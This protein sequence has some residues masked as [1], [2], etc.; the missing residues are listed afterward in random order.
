METVIGPVYAAVNDW[1]VARVSLGLPI[2]LPAADGPAPALLQTVLDELREYFAGQRQ[3]FDLPLDWRGMSPFDEAAR[4]AAGAIPYGQTR[5]YGQ[6]AVQLGRAGAARAVGRAMA[7][8]PLPLLIPCHRVLAADGRLRGFA[9]PDGVES[10]ARL[11]KLERAR[12][13]V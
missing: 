7:L 12:L 1:G 3:V 8:N 13:V 4:R 11:L 10:K 6:L 5:T 2:D 9:A